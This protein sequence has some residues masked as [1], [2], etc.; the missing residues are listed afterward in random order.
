MSMYANRWIFIILLH[1]V[2]IPLWILLYF[3]FFPWL[4][5]TSSCSRSDVT[6]LPFGPQ[7]HSSGCWWASSLEILPACQ[8][9]HSWNIP[10]YPFKILFFW[11]WLSFLKA[12]L[13]S[14]LRRTST[15]PLNLF[16]AFRQIR[17]QIFAQPPKKYA[18]LRSLLNLSFSIYIWKIITDAC[19]IGLLRGLRNIIHT[20]LCTESRIRKCGLLLFYLFK[21][22]AHPVLFLHCSFILISIV[23]TWL[24]GF[25]FSLPRRL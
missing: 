25:L 20:L 5:L 19:F 22:T 17:S 2:V 9:K 3:P 1:F 13:A 10:Y 11:G 8:T 7:S 12:S 18:N 16:L 14:Q 21:L 24:E 6:H 4:T 23:S 15:P